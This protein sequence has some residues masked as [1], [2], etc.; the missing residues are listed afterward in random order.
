MA[1]EFTPCSA[2]ARRTG[3]QRSVALAAGD[4]S[5]DQ[6]YFLSRALFL[7]ASVHALL[8]SFPFQNGN[9]GAA[10]SLRAVAEAIRYLDPLNQVS[11]LEG[12]TY[13]ANTLLRDTDCM[14]MAHA[15]EVRTPLLHHPLWEYVL[16]LAGQAEARPAPSQASSFARRRPALARGNL[17]AAP[18]WA[19]LFPLSVGC[20]TG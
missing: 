20:E 13:M 9:F 17:P 16:P 14:S 19:S 3:R 8:P 7:P 2:G 4:Y 10:S 18:R 12:S 11:V 1:R 6:P 5:A 15:L